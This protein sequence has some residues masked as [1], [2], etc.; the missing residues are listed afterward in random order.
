MF[1]NSSRNQES[2]SQAGFE[3]FNKSSSSRIVQD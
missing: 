3:E 1:P 2:D